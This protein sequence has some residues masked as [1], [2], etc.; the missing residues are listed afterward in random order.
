MAARGIGG[1]VMRAFGARDHISTVTDVV[2]LTPHCIRV[3][4]VSETLF[5]D[6]IDAPTS[7]V[8][9]WFPGEKGRE[10][11][12]GYTFSKANAQTGEFS[13]DF[14]LHEPSGPASS[15]AATAVPGS[16]IPFNSM[17]SKPFEVPAENPPSGY[18]LIGDAASLIAI[19]SIIAVVPEDIPIELYLEQHAA[20]DRDLP[21]NSHPRLNVTWVHRS[22]A[23]TLASA[24]QVRDWSNWYAW[25]APE[26]GS[27]KEI[28]KR[29]KD[30]GFPRAEIH[31]QAYWVQG[32]A[33]GTD[34]GPDD[35][36]APASSAPTA[37]VDEPVAA[38]S[39]QPAVQGQWRANAAGRLLAPLKR[40]LILAGILQAIVTLIGLAPF[41]V[42]VELGRRLVD[43][44]DAAELWQL[45]FVALGLI[46][47]G[48]LLEAALSLWLHTVDARFSRDLRQRLLTKLSRLP[49]G[50]FT[51][52][53]SGTV[54]TLVPVS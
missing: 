28:R 17:G 39:P 48:L 33:M 5:S 7:W 29:L 3:S 18:L 6:A 12:R 27:L 24:L 36:D 20:Q 45:G 43:G 4:F 32:K 13:I 54:K 52:R 2:E 15:W 10:F 9:G 37:T 49:L 38:Q 50:W 31:A 16:A 26:S 42:L 47:L 25:T 22:D 40:T 14:V 53:D 44:A 34:R 41:V 46:G 35:V 11:Q 51:S 8:R 30:F 19:N 1:T 21:L 23:S